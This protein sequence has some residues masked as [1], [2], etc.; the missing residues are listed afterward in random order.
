MYPATSCGR[1]RHF[2]FRSQSQETGL[3][4]ATPLRRATVGR[5]RASAAAGASC[6][7]GMPLA[8]VWSGHRNTSPSRTHQSVVRRKTDEML[9]NPIHAFSELS[10][11]TRGRDTEF[12]SPWH[13]DG[14][15]SP[16]V[17]P[18]AS[19][20]RAMDNTRLFRVSL[21]SDEYTRMFAG[22]SSQATRG[23][24]SFRAAGSVI[25]SKS[26]FLICETCERKI[27]N[28]NSTIT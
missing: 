14:R 5:S 6:R 7:P 15:T 13:G 26:S 10:L 17:H 27:P 20:L 28:M 1:R 11:K 12:P 21:A 25:G 9:Q 2:S 4:R 22:S 3:P 19:L 8:G 18:W 24:R 16:C 23:F